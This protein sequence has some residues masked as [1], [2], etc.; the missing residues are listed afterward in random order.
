V[1][2]RV[3]ESQGEELKTEDYMSYNFQYIHFM[4]QNIFQVFY[5]ITEN[6]GTEPNLG[7]NKIRPVYMPLC[8]AY[9]YTK[10]KSFATCLQL[11]YRHPL[12]CNTSYIN[13][14]L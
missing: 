14:I 13:T 9:H 12:L 4:K 6:L 10:C 8:S 2:E 11:V 5:V 3:L 7:I 1:T